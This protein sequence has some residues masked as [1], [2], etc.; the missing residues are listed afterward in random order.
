ML[1]ESVGSEIGRSN[2]VRLALRGVHRLGPGS[3]MVR[4]ATHI[5][6]AR[7]GA[8]PLRAANFVRPLVDGGPA[9]LRIAE[10]VE[11]ARRTVWLT[12]AFIERDVEM[13]GGHGTFFEL[14]DRAAARGVDVRA[15]FW[16]EPEL[17]T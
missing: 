5:P 3:L 6:S 17:G 4:D 11:A 12:V 9:F 8:Y 15:L 14:L 10:A 7:T 13:P 2:V 16:R 1:R